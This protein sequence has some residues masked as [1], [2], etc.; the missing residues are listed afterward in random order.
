MGFQ[1]IAPVIGAAISTAGNWFTNA[2]NLREQRNINKQ[3][4]AQQN[5]MYDRQRNDAIADRQ[6][7]NIYNSPAE[8][9]K[10]LQAAGLNPNLVY[11]NGASATNSVKTQ[12]ASFGNPS[13]QAARVNYDTSA[14]MDSIMMAAQ[15]KKIDADT[16]LTDEQIKNQQWLRDDYD[17]KIRN[18][19]TDTQ[20]KGLQYHIE[21]YLAANGIQAEKAKA[22]LAKTVADTKVNLS[23]AEQK[24]IQTSSNVREAIERIQLMKINAARTSADTERIK[25]QTQRIMQDYRINQLEEVAAKA[26]VPRNSPFIFKMIASLVDDLMKL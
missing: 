26:G 8:Q 19:D 16:R 9:M 25:A 22:D 13:S 14:I 1:A 12:Q 10:R 23:N 15:L 5:A 2:A 7:E 18:R 17:S 21:T 20:R 11:G 4:I 24:I 6:F 3:N